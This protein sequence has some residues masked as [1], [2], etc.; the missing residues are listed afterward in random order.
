MGGLDIRIGC[1]DKVSA[2]AIMCVA[3]APTCSKALVTLAMS[4][5]ICVAP[6]DVWPTFCA[7]SLCGFLAGGL[8][9]T[10]I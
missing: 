8:S 6:E 10:E 4:A 2:D 3:V 7:I 9:V 1:V 5:E